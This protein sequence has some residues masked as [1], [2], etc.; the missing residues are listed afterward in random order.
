MDGHLC[1]TCN[2]GL[3]LYNIIVESICSAKDCHASYF[4]GDG[5]LVAWELLA[6]GD[7]P[8]STFLRVSLAAVLRLN[9]CL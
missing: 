7:L 2:L 9:A 3:C 5:W 8:S 4:A 1:P 6:A